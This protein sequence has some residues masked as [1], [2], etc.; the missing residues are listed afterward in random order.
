MTR[1]GF[2]YPALLVLVFFVLVN[3]GLVMAATLWDKNPVA[4]VDLAGEN[5]FNANRT[6]IYGIEGFNGYI[7]SLEGDKVH[8]SFSLNTNSCASCHFSHIAPGEKL[9]FQRSVYNT[10]T[11]CHFNSTMNTYDILAGKT[12]GGAPAGGG[13]FY[14]GEFVS[15]PRKGTSYH[16][17]T[18]FHTIGDAPGAKFTRRNPTVE[19]P[20]NWGALFTC[21]SC[22]GAHG[23][24]SGRHLPYNPN[25]WIKTQSARTEVLTDVYGKPGWYTIGDTSLVP[26]YYSEDPL[27]AVRVED[28]TGQNV[29]DR[30]DINHATGTVRKRDA[31]DTLTPAKVTF[32]RT[33]RVLLD[34]T[35]PFAA[36]ENVVYRGG[37]ADFCITCHVAYRDYDSGTEYAWHNNFYHKAGMDISNKVPNEQSARTAMRLELVGE[38]YRLT[39]LTCHYAHGTDT[40]LM[41]RRGENWTTTAELRDLSN[42][43]GPDPTDTVK[44]RYFDPD[45]G[46]GYGGRFEVCYLC[47]NAF[48]YEPVVTGTAPQHNGV[49]Q[50]SEVQS[51]AF[52]FNTALTGDSVGR[53]TVTVRDTADTNKVTQGT[54]VYDAAAKSVSLALPAGWLEAGR[55][56]EVV[57]SAGVRAVISQYAPGVSDH[58]GH[59]FRFSTAN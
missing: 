14:D 24:Y 47:H 35:N 56:Y 30:F 33:L 39:C 23:T 36:N 52:V 53:T 31:E 44:L 7:R 11:S 49:V 12:P 10:C 25:G 37:T 6:G 3:I 41:R 57:L 32:Y 43:I 1:R 50:H 9:L 29:T 42:Y 48:L 28:G 40:G 19:V 17:A 15:E 55:E 59:T 8:H 27:Y 5:I 20:G 45:N 58:P 54:P 2:R 38:E 51:V 34:I 46:D 18:G 13:R 22:H 21:G 26:W 16:L 4:R